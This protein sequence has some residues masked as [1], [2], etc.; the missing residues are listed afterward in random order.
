[1]AMSSF[2]RDTVGLAIERGEL[3]ARGP[4]DIHVRA[5]GKL[6]GAVGR[7]ATALEDFAYDRLALVVRAPGNDPESTLVLHGRGEHLP[8]ELDLTVNLHGARLAARSLV[9]RIGR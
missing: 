7:I 3:R 4:G 9:S 1:M 6:A 5:P 2:R 8:Q